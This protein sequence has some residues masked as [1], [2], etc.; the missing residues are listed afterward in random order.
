MINKQEIIN[1]I[2][3]DYNSDKNNIYEFMPQLE[4]QNPYKDRKILPP[5]EISDVGKT[6]LYEYMQNNTEKIIN[7]IIK[8]EHESLIKILEDKKIIEHHILS[9]NF[10]TEL[11]KIC[12]PCYDNEYVISFIYRSNRIDEKIKQIIE[13]NNNRFPISDYLEKSIPINTLNNSIY[14]TY[15]GCFSTNV[16]DPNKLEITID[17]EKNIKI[18]NTNELFINKKCAKKIIVDDL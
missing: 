13:R 3:Q 5:L 10:I 12:S 6:D 14:I 2:R 11:D 9:K 4:I 15:V 16:Y 8:H 1:K 18:Q 7:D 17:S